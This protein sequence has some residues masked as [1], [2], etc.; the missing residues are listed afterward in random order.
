MPEDEITQGPGASTEA[1]PT[2][3]EIGDPL[4]L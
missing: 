3:G 2:T 1:T 4:K